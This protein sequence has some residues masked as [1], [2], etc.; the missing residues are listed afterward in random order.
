MSYN[1]NLLPDNALQSVEDY[2]LTL[3]NRICESLLSFETADKK[4]I[5]DKWVREAGGGGITRV[6]ENGDVFEK[7]G[8]NFSHITGD[9]LPASATEKRPELAGH[10]FHALGVSV[11]IHPYNPYVPTTHLNVR[12]FLALDKNGNTQ[13]WFGGG[14][15]LTPYYGFIEDAKFWHETAFNACK[16][17]G[18]DLYHKCKLA[19]DEYFFLKHRNEARGIGGL[20]FDD[21]NEMSFDQCFAFMQS[22]GEHFLK[23]YIPIVA[24]RKDTDFGK[25]EK[26]FQLI[27]RGRYVEFNLIYDRGTL[28]GLHSNGR[29]ESIFV[30]LPLEVC[31][32]Y[33]WQP[34]PGSAE[35]KLYTDFLPKKDW[36]K[37]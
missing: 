19:C 37:N 12:F 11:V 1:N 35:A 7:A 8:V 32:R 4:F 27:R 16:S 5:T 33:D 17:F 2:L 3:Q 36:L 28:F 9:R 15:D 18:D 25:R 30:S 29:T 10:K 34:E 26:D 14:F 31:W 20:F 23:A 21:F 13:W 6:F 24:K 22:V